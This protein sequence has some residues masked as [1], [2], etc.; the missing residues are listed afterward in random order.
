MEQYRIEEL[1]DQAEFIAQEYWGTNSLN[2]DSILSAQQISVS[3]GKYA[4]A[5]DGLLE[6]FN[7]RFHIYV[8][9][10]RGNR[11]GSGRSRFT[12]GHELGHFFIDEH[13]GPM[14]LGRV[15]PHSSI[16]FESN[17]IVEREADWFATNLL[18]PRD[19]F[20]KKCKK[21]LTGLQ[22]IVNLST[23]FETS[24]TSTALRYIKTYLPSSAVFFWRERQCVWHQTS[25]DWHSSVFKGRRL[26]MPPQGSAT[27]DV[28][29][30]RLSNGVHQRGTVLSEWK[31][32][33]PASAHSNSILM[34]QAIQLGRHGVLTLLYPA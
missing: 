5:F 9:T 10:E 1:A 26:S 19:R 22:G 25:E 23:T 34:E 15:D 18:M 27:A 17:S 7:G 16:A 29:N 20:I 30:N 4:N 32:H 6:Y 11:E 3:Y 8:N 33:L 14:K 24:I 21:E 2:I 28:I 12:I 31:S 13:R